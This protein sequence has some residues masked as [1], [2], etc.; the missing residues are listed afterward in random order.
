MVQARVNHAAVVRGRLLSRPGVSIDHADG[1]P[2]ARERER[3]G[4][5]DNAGADD[6]NHGHIVAAAARWRMR[7]V[8]SLQGSCLRNAR[9]LRASRVRTGRT[10]PNCFSTRVTK[11]TD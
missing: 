8:I 1:A 11:S 9:S 7:A 2:T 10:W 5:T 4:E 6:D 3:A